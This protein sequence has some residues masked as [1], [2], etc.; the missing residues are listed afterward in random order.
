MFVVALCCF[1]IPAPGN[2]APKLHRP[3]TLASIYYPIETSQ[4][5]RETH[6]FTVLLFRLVKLG[7]SFKLL[8]Y[9]TGFD[10]RTSMPPIRGMKTLSWDFEL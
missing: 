6:D 1:R 8:S 7:P 4:L 10:S 9:G 2:G 3:Q 5:L